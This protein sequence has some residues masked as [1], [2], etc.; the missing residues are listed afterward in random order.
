MTLEEDNYKPYIGYKPSSSKQG[1]NEWVGYEGIQQGENEWVGS[2]S[3]SKDP[4]NTICAAEEWSKVNISENPVSTLL[5]KQGREKGKQ[6]PSIGK[7]ILFTSIQFCENLDSAFCPP[8]AEGIPYP[9][10]FYK[11]LTSIKKRKSD[12]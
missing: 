1:E 12:I 9:L 8:S 2:E 7:A 5:G 6:L 10:S 3:I 4:L 11:G